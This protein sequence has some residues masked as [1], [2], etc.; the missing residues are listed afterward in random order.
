[1]TVEVMEDQMALVPVLLVHKHRNYQVLHQIQGG[2]NMARIATSLPYT[3]KE[4]ATG[5][6]D[7]TRKPIDR[8]VIHTMV[9]TAD[10]AS[11][12]FDNPTQKV[13]AHYGVKLDGSLIHWLEETFTAYHAGDYA[14]NQRSI[15]IE[16]EDK[17]DYNGV[18]TDAL[19][20]ESAKL[21]RD[22]CLYYN[23]PIDRQHILKHSEVIATG[24]P[25]ALDI[26]RIVR[27]AQ[28]N[29]TQQVLDAAVKDR[30]R[31]YNLWKSLCVSLGVQVTTDLTTTNN[32]AQDIIKNLKSRPASC[33]TPA[34]P[35]QV[36]A[37]KDIQQII[38]S[39]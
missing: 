27:E 33:P 24:C 2:D 11:A 3:E 21:V 8:I 19:Y 32:K 7:Q 35:R 4:V 23:I 1:V 26:D 36:K 5:N 13:S 10:A 22:I 37:L 28:I 12:R 38:N 16:H 15:G 31:N 14:M 17:G 25:D 20:T 34:D 30:D 9:G 18:R 29:S 39:L 6:Y